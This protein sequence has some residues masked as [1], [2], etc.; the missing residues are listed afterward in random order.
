MEKLELESNANLKGKRACETCK[1]RKKRCYGGL[2]CEYCVKIKNPQGCEY[3]TRLTKKK[4]KVS[5]RYIASLK[6]KIRLLENR[7]AALTKATSNSKAQEEFVGEEN[8]LIEV[9]PG[10]RDDKLGRNSLESIPLKMTDSFCTTTQQTPR[11]RYSG[12]SACLSFLKRI[13]HTLLSSAGMEKLDQDLTTK[14]IDFTIQVTWDQMWELASDI[15]RFQK[16]RELISSVG[17]II[18]SDYLFMD[19]SYI[20]SCVPKIFYGNRAQIEEEYTPKLFAEELALFYSY[21]ALGNLFKPARD[22]EA[23]TRPTNGFVYFERALQILS[24]LFKHFDKCAGPSLIQ[25]FLYVAYFGLSVDK[26]AF[27]YVMV[28]NAIR[29]AFTLGFHKNSETPKNNR[30]FWL[31]FLYDRLLAIRFGFPLLINERE[32]EIPSC[33][34]FE[35]DFLSVSLEK[36]H[37]EAQVSLAKITTNIIDRIYTRNSTSFVH[38]CHAVLKELKDWFDGLPRELKFDYNDF[39]LETSR[40]TINLHIN[41]NYLIIVTTRSVVFYV[42]N[43]LISSGK[44]TDEM[45]ASNLREII[46]VL[47]DA[48]VNAAQIQSVI[49]T[50]LYYAGR[51][52]SRSFLDCHYIFNS[53]VVLILAAFVQSLPNYLITESTEESILFNHVQ[54]NLDVLQ[55]I[56]QY[57]IA[58]YNFNKQL[59]ELIE[60]ISCEQVQKI[61]N[62]NLLRRPLSTI[63]ADETFTNAFQSPAVEGKTNL[64]DNQELL[65]HIDLS[66]VLEL[67]MSND[68]DSSSEFSYFDEDDFLKFSNFVL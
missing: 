54:D 38:N 60:L 15:P 9:I 68:G 67:M 13:Q 41:Y 23:G 52:M 57:N 50:R 45:F 20:D 30:I 53:S 7:L 58:G 66:E 12:D 61:H 1:K 8:P 43:K 65:T 44:T 55:Q 35:L 32:I 64:Y 33:S 4:V 36:Y 3:K 22:S 28:G 11:I 42:F 34:A 2:P 19:N 18:G 49:L 14:H 48:S 46:I 5:E 17:S 40:P 21:L 27:A 26:S 24:T 31:C 10:E 62:G 47:L 37:F 56:S 39:S 51:M 63:N 59:T 29:V 25:A 16:V 6:T